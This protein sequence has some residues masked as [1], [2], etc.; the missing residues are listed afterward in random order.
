MRTVT[1]H[2]T[3]QQVLLIRTVT[4]RYYV[5]FR[6]EVSYMLGSHRKSAVIDDHGKP[7]Q[8]SA[9]LPAAG[10]TYRSVYLLHQDFSMHRVGPHGSGSC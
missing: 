2:D 1:L 10:R 8:V 5:A 4:K 9:L 6:L 7:F 3:E